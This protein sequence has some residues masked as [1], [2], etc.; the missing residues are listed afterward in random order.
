MVQVYGLNNLTNDIRANLGFAPNYFF[1]IAWSILCP[2]IVTSLMILSLTYT[3]PLKYG[4]YVF[5][6]WSLALGWCMNVTFILPIPIVVIYAFIRYSD[7]KKSLKERISLLF[8]PT[9]NR[10]SIKYQGDPANEL[11]LTS[12]SQNPSV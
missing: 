3:Y 12:D 4:Q 5:P 7:S 2:L 6:W 8:V 10:K 11:C 1:R 9:I